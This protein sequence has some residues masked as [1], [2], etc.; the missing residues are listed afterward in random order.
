MTISSMI[1]MVPVEGIEP[2]TFGLQ[3]RTSRGD[4]A[5]PRP[6]KRVDLLTFSRF[7]HVGEGGG[8]GWNQRSQQPQNQDHLFSPR[9]R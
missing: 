8:S 5:P 1:S 6:P 7:R 3:N 2:P 4:L 9:S